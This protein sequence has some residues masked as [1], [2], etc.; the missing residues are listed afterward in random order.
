MVALPALILPTLL[1]A[2]SAHAQGGGAASKQIGTQPAASAPISDAPMTNAPVATMGQPTGAVSAQGVSTA[3]ATPPQIEVDADAPEVASTVIRDAKGKEIV[4]VAQKIPGQLDVPQAPIAVMDEADIEAYGVNSISDLLDAISPQTGTGRGRGA[5]MPVILVNGQRISSFREIRDYPPEAIRRVEILPEEVALRFGYSPDQRVVNIILKDNFRSKGGEL[6]FSSPTRGG[7]STTSGQANLVAINKGKRLNISLR[8]DYTSPLTDAERGVREAPSSIPTVSTDPQ[9]GNDRTL[10]DS[11][12]DYTINSTYTMPLSKKPLSGTLTLNGTFARTDTNSLNGLNTA[13]VTDPVTGAVVIRTFPGALTQFSRSDTYSAGLTLNKPVG[14]WNLQATFDGSHGEATTHTS[15]RVDTSLFTDAV[16]AGTLSATGTLP[17]LADAGQSISTSNTNTV[18]TLVTFNGRGLPLPAGKIGV[19][20]KGGFAYTGLDSHSTLS[21]IGGSSLRRGDLS[22]GFNL[23]IPITSRREHFGE[24]LGDI[25]ANLSGGIDKLSDFG[26]ITNW[27]GGAT[28]G[29]T[30]T[31]SFQASYLFKQVAPTLA[32]LG[33]AQTITFNQSVYDFT[34]GESVLATVITGGNRNLLA[35]NQNDL[36]LGINWSLPVI[37]NSNLIVEYFDNRTKN[38]PTAFPALTS[39][40]L[41]AYP[42]RVTRDA[43]T[44]AITQIDET[45]VNIAF[46]HEKRL[47]WGFN[48][49]G[50]LGKP[51][52]PV[53]RRGMFGGGSPG[54]GGPGSGGFAG[55]G[56]S[57]DGPPPAAAGDGGSANGP[58]QASDGSG[59]HRGGGSFDGQRGGDGPPGE[60]GGGGPPGGGG[61][62]PRGGRN[63]QRYPGRWNISF[64]HTYNFIDTVQLMQGGP[65]LDLLNGDTISSGGGVARHALQLDAGGFY[66]G[67]GAR[68]NGTWSSVTHINASGAPGTSDLRFGA[69]TS[70]NLRLFVDLGQQQ[71]L[72]K[73]S[74]FFKN[75]RLSFGVNNL[76]DSVSRV[77]DGTGA[78]PLS[79]QWPY[80]SA[81]RRTLKLELRKMF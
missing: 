28:W 76:L 3:P 36:K 32:N 6:E 74:A 34:R 19:T 44:G 43:A 65:P 46:Q 60:G 47:R 42:G 39:A 66:K 54:G 30:S 1:A 81:N 50:N 58:R 77:T 8:A 5:T 79:Y 57:V 61:G 18:T 40:V 51:L 72:V 10:V 12:H 59:G 4:V 41:A 69:T 16:A 55:R 14:L 7:T 17:A 21:T 48:L 63:G 53:R 73:K 62:P 9:P 23:A 52:P 2:T 26:V 78:T 80:L 33:A 64:Y 75:A 49:S 45:P 56:A 38:A 71:R 37:K 70:L 27:S 15:N 20:V 35:E 31:L 29:I 13:S 25:T 68:L 22:T 24:A 11:T 67:F